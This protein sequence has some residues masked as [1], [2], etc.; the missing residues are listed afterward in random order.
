M[1]KMTCARTLGSKPPACALFAYIVTQTCMKHRTCNP[2]HTVNNRENCKRSTTILA[3][4]PCA[5]SPARAR[6]ATPARA[7]ALARTIRG[8][9]RAEGP[10][11]DAH[12]RAAARARTLAPLS[13][14]PYHH[15]GV[16]LVG[17]TVQ[18]STQ[19]SRGSWMNFA[20]LPRQWSVFPDTVA[21][22]VTA[23]DRTEIQYYT[24]VRASGL[25]ASVGPPWLEASAHDRAAC[26]KPGPGAGWL[27]EWRPRPL[28][29][30]SGSA[31]LRSEG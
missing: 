10:V 11:L 22:A 1:N 23:P 21:R 18:C 13:T 2:L 3:W 15:T 7:R 29:T 6:S 16:N 14:R 19:Y 31:G 26:N 8:R 17:T 9:A 27:A 25:R 4:F 24:L 5:R 20:T 30:E 28:R 12:A